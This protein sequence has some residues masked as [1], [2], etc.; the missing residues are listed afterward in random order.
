MAGLIFW[1]VVLALL[2][3]LEVHT[4]QMVAVWFAAGSLVAF[5]VALAGQS[6]WV[7]GV[8]FVLASTVLLLLTRPIVRKVVKR[9]FTPTNADM[10][11]GSVGKVI[12]TIR[13]GDS[14]RVFADG[15]EWMAVSEDGS[16][17][18]EGTQVLVRQIEGVKLIVTKEPETVRS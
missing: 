17:I 9:P 7:Q 5:F 8:V 11:I 13:S 12:Q 14:G 18:P 6:F 10:T 4:M 16:E 3:V 2:I 1:A 15:L